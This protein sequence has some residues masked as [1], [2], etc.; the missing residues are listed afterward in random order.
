[1]NNP[2]TR[3][4]GLKMLVGLGAIA[5]PSAKGQA[6]NA[7]ARPPLVAYF[8]RTGNTRVVALQ[9]RRAV[10]GEL[11]EIEPAAA[12]PEDCRQTVEQAKR[13]SDAAFEPPLKQLVQ[14]IAG[15]DTI[16]L[17]FPIWGMTAPPVI[18][19]FVARHDLAGKRLV[20]FSRRLRGRPKPEHAC[21]PRTACAD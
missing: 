15:H 20:P 11:F 3:R 16:Y 19:T 14:N 6:Q 18:R 21:A 10:S 12:Y 8:S 17:G 9:I 2:F 13:E 5:S 4:D 7:A 1:M